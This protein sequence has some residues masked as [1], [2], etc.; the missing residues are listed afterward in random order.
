[1]PPLPQD[2]IYRIA[3]IEKGK[4]WLPPHRR[5]KCAESASNLWIAARRGETL[6]EHF[7]GIPEPPSLLI[8]LSQIQIELGMVVSQFKR[9]ETESL[10]IKKS[11]VGK[12]S[13]QPCVGQVDRVMWGSA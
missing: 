7:N 11:L 5:A 6:F 10:S 1:M 4:D 9:F 12:S 2:S 3:T 8:N 13:Q